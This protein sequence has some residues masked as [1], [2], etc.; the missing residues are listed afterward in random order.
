MVRKSLWHMLSTDL[1][2]GIA[3]AVG[4]AILGS[5]GFYFS[6]P[7]ASTLAGLA[8]FVLIYLIRYKRILPG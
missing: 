7:L 8:L 4:A 5:L 6:S 2:T 1:L 3:F